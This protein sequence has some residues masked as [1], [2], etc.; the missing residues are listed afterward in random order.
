MYAGVPGADV[1]CVWLRDCADFNL[2]NPVSQSFVV[3]CSCNHH[4][5]WFDVPMYNQG[6]Q[7][8]KVKNFTAISARPRQSRRDRTE[9]GEISVR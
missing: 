9:I 2:P 8:V 3:C 5:C 6:F 4:I 1:L 7:V